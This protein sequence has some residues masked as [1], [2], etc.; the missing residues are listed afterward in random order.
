NEPKLAERL[1][2]AVYPGLQGGPLLN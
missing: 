1:N 2:Q